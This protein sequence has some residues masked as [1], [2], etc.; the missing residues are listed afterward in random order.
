MHL[1]LALLPV[2]ASQVDYLFGRLLD[3]EPS[4]VPVLRDA[5]APYKEQLVGKLWAVAEAPEPGKETQR[6]RATVAL[7]KYDRQSK[8]WAEVSDAVAN[9][10]VAVNAIHLAAW[11]KSFR[12]VGDQLLPSL[13]AIYRDSGRRDTER[14]L[15]TDLL[16]DYAANQPRV[17]AD[18]LMAG[19]EKQFAV[20]YPKF[21]QLGE[22]G[23]PQLIEEIDRK[24]PDSANDQD[25]EKMAKRQANAAVVLLRMNR[26]AKV[27]PLLQHRPDPRMR[28]Y[29]I[30][31]LST[32]G[33]ESGTILKRL[34]EEPEITIRRA[35]VL[36][37][38]E[39]SEKGLSSENRKTLISKLKD[40]YRTARDPGLHAA[41]EWLA[42]QWKQEAWLNQVND[43][44]AKDKAQRTKRL[45]DIRQLIST[46][47]EKTSPQW[48]VNG[49]SQTM[50]VIPGPVEFVMGSPPTEA[51][52]KIDEPQHIRRIGRTFAVSAKSV[53][54]GQYRR[55]YKDYQ[56]GADVFTRRPICPRWGLAG[57]RRLRI[58][59]G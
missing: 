28:S 24:L 36:S 56:A 37:L 13:A 18:L 12:P 5:L 45:H 4:E 11:L 9:D 58:A 32:L 21:I 16:A 29:L 48:Y 7:V 40:I 8:R 34:D 27:W 51:D 41:A 25:Q 49:Q 17:L 1:S 35:L 30:H 19:D 31:R 2:D 6:L 59:C 10:L 50:I 44:W 26:P 33:V 54:V 3:A 15:A 43:E 46:D 38:G 47:K 14:S 57:T 55:F 42:R 52:R 22:Q 53:T 39:F 20:V 23:L